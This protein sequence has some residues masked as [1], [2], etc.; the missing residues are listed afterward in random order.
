MDDFPYRREF[1]VRLLSL[2]N[3]MDLRFEHTDRAL[4]LSK[5]ELERR[6]EGMNEFRQQLDR[7]AGT[8]IARPELCAEIEKIEL[9]IAPLIKACN[10]G[11]GSR[12]WTDYFAMALISALIVGLFRLLIP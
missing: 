6:L 4:L 3:E 10:Q 9:K 8:F 1:E 12:R 2:E 5:S 7:Q 11:E